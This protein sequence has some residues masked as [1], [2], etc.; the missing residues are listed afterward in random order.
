M[1]CLQYSPKL[2]IIIPAHNEEKRLLPSLYRIDAFLQAQPYTAEVIVVENGSSDRTAEVVAAFAELHPYTRLLQV[3]TR[4]KGLAVKAGM[5]AA[6]GDYRFICDADLSMPIEELPRFFQPEYRD[7]DVLIGSR[8][9]EGAQRIG[10]PFKRHLMGRIA[11][12]LIT[13]TTVPNCK[14][15]QC[16]FKL[17]KRGAAEALFNAQQMNGIGFD[18]ELLYLA[19]K[20]GYSIAEVPITWYYDAD[21][22][23]RLFQDSLHLLLELWQIHRNDHDGVYAQAKYVFSVPCY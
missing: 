15:T 8:E 14:D 1:S 23:M 11:N 2:S 3:E 10:E 19:R 5:L 7:F 16:G 20:R 22:R 12:F 13:L 9:A 18:I 17:F 6:S 4:G 21:S